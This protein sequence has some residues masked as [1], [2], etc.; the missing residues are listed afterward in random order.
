MKTIMVKQGES[1]PITFTVTDVA[2]AAV[3]LSAAA[4]TLGVKKTK[5]D[6]DYVFSKEDAEFGKSQAALG[7]VTVDLTAVDTDRPEGTYIGELKLEWPGHPS[8]VEKSADFYLK[9][10]RAITA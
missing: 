6:E 1:K 2:E 8:M 3:D 7:I 5:S 9:I 4:L 10:N